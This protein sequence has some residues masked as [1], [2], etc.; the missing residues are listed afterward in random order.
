[1]ISLFVILISKSIGVALCADAEAQGIGKDEESDGQADEER[2]EAEIKEGITILFDFLNS[3]STV[4]H[5]KIEFLPNLNFSE[6]LEDDSNMDND[7]LPLTDDSNVTSNT[8]V[9]IN[10]NQPEND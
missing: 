6:D 7:N 3:N 4:P 9:D 10:N 5:D 2:I 8:S 1:M